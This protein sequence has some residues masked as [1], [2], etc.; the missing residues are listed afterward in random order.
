M[1]FAEK[2]V[3]QPRSFTPQFLQP[4]QPSDLTHEAITLPSD[5]YTSAEVYKL[6][7]ARIFGRTWCYVGNMSR[8]QEAGSYFTVTLAGQPLIILRDRAGTLR[9]FFNVCPH[10]G[11][12]LAL[13]SG[14]CHKLTCLYHAWTFDLEGNLRGAPEMDAA[15]GFELADHR[16][17]SVKVDTWGSFIFVNLDP[18][19]QP[20]EAQLS[21]LPQKF[22]RYRLNEWIEL[23]RA[24]YWV[25]ANWKLFYE[26]TT[27]SYHEPNVH[28]SVPKF[29]T[30]IRSEAKDYYYSQFTPHTGLDQEALSEL[31]SNL[32]LEESVSQ[33]LSESEL[34]SISV[35][36]LFP[37]FSWVLGAGFGTTYLIDP[38]GPA[39]THVQISW[40][41]PAEVAKSL[42]TVEPLVQSFETILQ[43]DL[44][45][46]PHIQKGVMSSG[47]RQG[48]LSPMRE[49]GIHLFQQRVMQYLTQDDITKFVPQPA[50]YSN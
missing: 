7:Q 8:L 39:R 48:R 46:L 14:Q 43:E 4:W 49:M 2:G 26:N 6:E 40:I 47:Y 30:G 20:L 21:D 45:L 36:C 9:A 25:D 24:D 19:S 10:R 16:L 1:V 5:L 38:Q 42:E 29:Y 11:A 37:N 28:Q 41:A 18:D 33:G 22:E 23:H 44:N 12:P 3:N 35:L 31:M 15:A 34:N 13:E 50:F 27:E 17:Q 32:P